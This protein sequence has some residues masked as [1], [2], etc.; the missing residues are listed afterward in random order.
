MKKLK[1]LSLKESDNAYVL[2]ILMDDGNSESISINKDSDAYQ[3][4]MS[5]LKFAEKIGKN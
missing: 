5:L 3:I 2:K 1:Y 4:V